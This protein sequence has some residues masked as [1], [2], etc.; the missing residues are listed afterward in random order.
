MLT[1]RNSICQRHHWKR[2]RSH[3]GRSNAWDQTNIFSKLWLSEKKC[4]AQCNLTIFIRK[5]YLTRAQQLNKNKSNSLWGHGTAKWL[6]AQAAFKSDWG[7]LVQKIH[8]IP[9]SS[10]PTQTYSGIARLCVRASLKKKGRLVF[11][12]ISSDLPPLSPPLPMGNVWSSARKFPRL[13]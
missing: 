5:A 6:I 13:F 11:A 9:K 2:V 8:P 10:D 7:A 4:F 12:S 1:Q 3:L